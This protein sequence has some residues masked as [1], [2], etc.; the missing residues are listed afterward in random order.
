MEWRQRIF[1]PSGSKVIVQSADAFQSCV[2]AGP[3]ATRCAASGPHAG[4]AGMACGVHDCYSFTLCAFVTS[5]GEPCSGEVTSRGWSPRS[6]APALGEFARRLSQTQRACLGLSGAPHRK[7][8][9]GSNWRSGKHCMTDLEILSGY[10][11]N[12]TGYE[13]ELSPDLDL[14]EKQILDSFS[15]VQWAMFIQE[16]FGIELEAEEL[17]RDN[18]SS[19]S[20]VMALVNSKRSASVGHGQNR[21]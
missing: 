11:R 9:T 3:P 13:G 1:A 18:L 14:L 2:P 16:R 17:V 10:I 21:P 20:N 6:A 7:V 4:P 5:G 12:E 19:L 8:Q 15:I